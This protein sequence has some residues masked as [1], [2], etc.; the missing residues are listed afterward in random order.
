MKTIR[1][2]LLMLLLIPSFSGYA[3]KPA[4]PEKQYDSFLLLG[5]TAHIGNGKVIENSAIAVKNGRFL[6]VK[7]QMSQRID[8]AGFDTV[9]YLN[10]EHIYPGI[11]LPDNTLGLTEIDAVRATRDF[12]DAGQY[13]PN[14]RAVIA[15]NAESEVLHTVRS[16][17]VLISQATPRGG[18]LSGTSAIMNLDGWNWEDAALV[19]E[20]GVHLNWPR[21]FSQSG[22][23]Y[24]PGKIKKSDDSDERIRA[25]YTF[26]QKAKAYS[27]T[28]HHEEINLRFEAM[29]GI[30]DGSKQLYVHCNMVKEIVQVARFKREFRIPRL[31]IVGG[32][33]AWMVPQLLIENKI[34]VIYRRVNSLPL[35]PDDD[36]YLPYEIPSKLKEA[37]VLFC[38]DMAGDMEAMNGRNLPFMAGELT[39]YGFTSEEALQTVTLNAARILGI[40][41]EAGSLEAGKQ[42]TFFVSKGDALDIRT[43][44]LIFAWIAG[45]MINLDN[46]QKQLYRLYRSKYDDAKP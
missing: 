19:A 8:Q 13:N 41:Q 45:Q 16:N 14:L 25:V 36:V 38:L 1:H 28:D 31:V 26:F 29:K 20:D 37:G 6:F 18:V 43:N 30:F 5:G 22:P 17:G 39:G 24:N 34:S 7:N 42:A 40:E 21:R 2:I 15:F 12:M 23:W 35:R 10:G 11:I 3:Q 27:E 9:I 32:Y 33:D 4:P 46:H 44:D